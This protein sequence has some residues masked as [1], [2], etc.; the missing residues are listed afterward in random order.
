MATKNSVLTYDIDKLKDSFIELL[1]DESAIST[2]KE[3]LEN[4]IK[5]INSLEK[6]AAELKSDNEKLEELTKDINLEVVKSAY[7]EYDTYVDKVNTIIQLQ[8]RYD[9][10]KKRVETSILSDEEKKE[11]EKIVNEHNAIRADFAEKLTEL[12]TE[13]KPS[14]N[15]DFANKLI[16]KAES[17]KSQIDLVERFNK[18]KAELEEINNEIESLNGTREHLTNVIAN[19][20]AYTI[21]NFKAFLEQNG[22]A[23]THAE[24]IFEYL[25]DHSKALK[26]DKNSFKLR[27]RHPVRDAVIK[28]GL[29]PASVV[30]AGIG[31]VL[32]YI[33]S[34]GLVGGST[35][36]GIIPVSGTPGLTA[37]ATTMVGGVAGLALTP[38]VIKTKDEAVKLYYKARYKSAKTNLKDF[39]NGTK[40]ENLP[41]TDLMNKVENTK[42]SILQ[43]SQG[44]WF[45]KTLKFVPKHIL[46]TI[47]RNR[48][49]HIEKYTKDLMSI[50]ANIDNSNLS[51]GEKAEKLK[52]IYELLTQV[53]D[54]VGKD[55]AE[56]KLHALLT[57]DQEGNHSHKATIENIDIFAN[58]KIYLDTVG[59]ETNKKAKV[60]Q[61]KQ[62]KKTIKNLKQKTSTAA[63]ILDGERLIP[64]ML[65]YEA[66]YA[67][68]NNTTKTEYAVTSV[69]T[70]DNDSKYILKFDSGKSVVV[71]KSDIN[72]DIDIEKVKVGKSKIIIT[73]VDGSTSEIL[74]PVRITP[75]IE[76]ARRVMYTKITEDKEFITSLKETYD[77]RTINT[78]A[79][80]LKQWIN[81]P[82][83]R[84]PLTGKSR[85]LYKEVMAVVNLENDVNVTV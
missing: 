16:E 72:P 44:N 17:L 49:H 7:V 83:Q 8:T 20:G 27:K 63:Q 10:F 57:C 60:V 5:E 82:T 53:E 61:E 33:A 21:E 65:D 11:V 41:I 62:A 40:L 35:I 84:I 37:L 6:K 50:Y 23:T 67:K 68:F 15:N 47:N 78:L 26:V 38:V 80:K 13:L 85:E 1:S 22:F 76:T 42:H 28:K 69:V 70:T 64:R 79:S 4:I 66:T 71:N 14:S 34:S 73:Y 36:W 59:L 29:I 48:I 24:E 9:D 55:V 46:N 43:M 75:E 39:E 74:K 19:H 58:L 2:D 56:S 45:T 32:G 54:F 31:S 12:A 51:V 77:I 3:L 81:N 30:G 52:P 25:N 18:Q